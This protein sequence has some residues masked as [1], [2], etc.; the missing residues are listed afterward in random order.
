M[1]KQTIS[2]C[3]EKAWDAFSK[4]IRVRDALLTTGTKTRLRCVTCD[5]VK[6]IK[7]MDAGHFVQG[8]H[9]A[10][11]FDER[12]VHGQCQSCNRFKHGNLIPYYEYM[13]VRYGVEVIEELKIMN[14]Q[15][16]PFKREELLE[17]EKE[18]KEITEL[19]IKNN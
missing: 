2:K 17:M 4:M 13:K 3:K 10:T 8:R 19:Y 5:S 6:D 7:E 16:R 15:T 14:K 11:L 18:Y 1:K 9:N 12:N